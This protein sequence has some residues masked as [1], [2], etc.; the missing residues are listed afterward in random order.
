MKD[1]VVK[2][3][4][5]VRAGWL[6]AP[7]TTPTRPVHRN[8]GDTTV[9]TEATV[10]ELKLHA[11]QAVLPFQHLIEQIRDATSFHIVTVRADLDTKSGILKKKDDSDSHDGRYMVTKLTHRVAQ[12]FWHRG[13]VTSICDMVRALAEADDIDHMLHGIT[14]IF[15]RDDIEIVDIKDRINTSTDGGWSDLMLLIR[16]DPFPDVPVAVAI[17]STNV[18][19]LSRMGTFTRVGGIVHA[20]RP[21]FEQKKPTYWNINKYFESE[22]LNYLY[23]RPEISS[24]L[25]G[26][27]YTKGSAGIQSDK[28]TSADPMAASGWKAWDG[29]DWTAEPVIK[30]T[31]PTTGTGL[32]PH[33][34][35]LQIA[36]KSMMVARQGMQAH[37]A[38]AT[39]RYFVEMLIKCGGKYDAS[40]KEEKLETALQAL[41][42][43]F[44]ELNERHGALQT[45]SVHRNTAVLVDGS[46]AEIIHEVDRRAAEE[47]TAL[48]AE[49]VGLKVEIGLLRGKVSDP[50][51]PTA[52]L[53]GLRADGDASAS[54]IV[55]LKAEFNV[56]QVDNDAL[57]TENASLK[58]LNVVLKARVVM[59]EKSTVAAPIDVSTDT[60]LED[61]GRLMTL[62]SG[63][64]GGPGRWSV[65]GLT[66]RFQSS[67]LLEAEYDVILPGGKSTK[68]KAFWVILKG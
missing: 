25:V 40:T 44:D 64:K 50:E 8:L 20:D 43:R 10:S 5:Q 23:F 67:N 56:I 48:I 39:A 9:G 58:E 35:E 28:C 45:S 2:Q 16:E 7:G 36:L 14:A 26:K 17:S 1:L 29:S 41:Q 55:V 19:Q 4:T 30:V 34:C 59:L 21:V 22:T 3:S 61:R 60:A 18:P 24:W 6:R 65:Q 32:S 66:T 47:D 53:L 57:K 31:A 52:E 12:K 62:D 33:I 11:V 63:A 51:M 38:Y 42:E 68:Q 15:E 27:D 54:E 46:N 37:E 13:T 49:N